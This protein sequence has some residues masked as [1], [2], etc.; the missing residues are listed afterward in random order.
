ADF[1]SRMAGFLSSVVR[2]TV[3]SVTP[4][5]VCVQYT[6]NTEMK[7]LGAVRHLK[8]PRKII[9]RF[10]AGLILP[11]GAL[12]RQ[13]VSRC[14]LLSLRSRVLIQNRA[15]LQNSRRRAPDAQAPHCANK[16]R[17]VGSC[18]SESRRMQAGE[19]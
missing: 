10:I 16:L 7:S 8:F 15:L 5:A 1:A 6:A 12:H 17:S 13:L 18:E 3:W 14:G 9:L 19:F 4:L 2:R 11:G